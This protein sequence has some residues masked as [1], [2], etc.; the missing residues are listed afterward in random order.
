V[1]IRETTVGD[2]VVLMPV[3]N[4]TAAA[5]CQVLQQ[6]LKALLEG[7]TR[8]I[9]VDGSK[10]G[11]IGSGAM[12]VL[13]L[14]GRKLRPLGGRLILCALSDHVRQGFTIS[15]FDRDFTIVSRQETAVAKIHEDLPSPAGAVPP[16]PKRDALSEQQQRL[17]AL[18]ASTVA[19]GL[20]K[21]SWP[22]G[23]SASSASLDRIRGLASSI[24]EGTSGGQRPSTAKP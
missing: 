2:V 8:L 6:K 13:L 17:R 7:Q 5:D 1:E 10:V 19:K 14:M 16:L 18:F 21:V 23:G 4:L 9:V 15:G 20:K 11:Q 12:R 24:L 22:P 3:G